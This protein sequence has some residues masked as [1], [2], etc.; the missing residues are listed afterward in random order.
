M[1]F[2]FTHYMGSKLQFGKYKGHKV[3]LVVERDPEYL[4]YIISNTDIAFDKKVKDKV[5]E[6]MLER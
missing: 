1:G 4:D 3:E 5:Y 2:Q 6:K